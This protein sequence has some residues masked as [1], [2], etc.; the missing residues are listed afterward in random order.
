MTDL[1]KRLW[2]VIFYTTPSHDTAKNV[3]LNR[4]NISFGS[5]RGFTS[6]NI[7]LALS[8]SQLCRIISKS[9]SRLFK[10]HSRIRSVKFNSERLVGFGIQ[11]SRICRSRR[12]LS[13]AHSAA[14]SAGIAESHIN[15]LIRRQT[16][17]TATLASLSRL[18]MPRLMP[19]REIHAI[20]SCV[21]M[22]PIANLFWSLRKL[23]ALPPKISSRTMIML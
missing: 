22:N 13:N 2:I 4:I 7:Y 5:S 8:F 14:V 6:F 18:N 10:P 3:F 16:P 15:A 12:K 19:H 23:S 17:Y 11:I 9:F 1:F 20:F 21:R